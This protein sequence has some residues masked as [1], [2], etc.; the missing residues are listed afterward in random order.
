MT[1][2]NDTSAPAGRR[3]LGAVDHE[4]ARQ[5]V[6]P[7]LAEGVDLVGPGGLL[8]GLT[9]QVLETGLEVEM[10]DHLGYAK[11]GRCP[12]GGQTVAT[13]PEPRPWPSM[14]ARWR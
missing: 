4:L 8:A 14:T 1:E 7:A 9:E 12:E 6:E 10:D 13:A 2:S 5:L 3:S 11:H